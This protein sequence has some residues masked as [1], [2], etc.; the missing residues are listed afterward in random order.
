MYPVGLNVTA[1]FEVIPRELTNEELLKLKQNTQQRKRKEKRNCRRQRRTPR[2]FTVMGL[3]EAFANVLKMFE[4]M[5]LNAERFS[6]IERTVRG[7]L[8]PLWAPL[9]TSRPS[10][11]LSP[12]PGRY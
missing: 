3:A 8:P 7:L 1:L 9:T 6:L 11:D 2:K 12:R 5:D 4:K 10:F